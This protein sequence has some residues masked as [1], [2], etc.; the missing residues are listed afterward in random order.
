[1]GV[2][3]TGVPSHII[4]I[5][6]PPSVPPVEGVQGLM[7]G[8]DRGVRDLVTLCFEMV[9]RPVVWRGEGLQ[10]EGASAAG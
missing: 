5:Y 9:G 2:A 8:F 4:L 10:E 6:F 7:S 3:Q 1:M